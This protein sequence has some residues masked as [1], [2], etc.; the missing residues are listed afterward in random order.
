ML[1]GFT[2]AFSD[3]TVTLLHRTEEG[4]APL[5]E[6]APD[7]SDLAEQMADLREQAEA[8]APEGIATKLAIPASQILYTSIPLLTDQDATAQVHAAL[9]GLTPYEVSELRFDWTVEAGRAHLA[10]VAR[11]TLHEAEGFATDFGFNPVAF[12]A[13][14]PEGRLP[15][16]PFFGL[17][18]VAARF[19]GGQEVE[20]DDML[21]RPP[22]LAAVPDPAD[23]EALP[24]PEDPE[25]AFEAEPQP[26]PVFEA[27]PQAE[28]LAEVPVDMDIAEEEEVYAFLP[29]D[30][31]AA[32]EPE[33]EP[34]QELPAAPPEDEP[35]PL[36]LE[37]EP[38]AEAD[39]VEPEMIAP[40][41]PAA[42]DEDDTALPEDDAEFAEFPP[43]GEEELV[44]DEP[45]EDPSRLPGAESA[46]AFVVQPAATQPR[47]IPRV[48]EPP[49]FDHPSF[50]RRDTS[51]R[52]DRAPP[53]FL[54]AGPVPAGR[55]P[56]LGAPTAEAPFV[57]FAQRSGTKP[58][59]VPPPLR[60][61]QNRARS[62]AGR[63]AAMSRPRPRMLGLLLTLLLLGALALVAIASSLFTGGN[64]DSASAGRPSISIFP[65]A[66]AATR[67]EQVVIAAPAPA[68]AFDLP[69]TLIE[70]PI[71][72]QDTRPAAPQMLAQADLTSSLPPRLRPR[73]AAAVP[74]ATSASIVALTGSRP[75]TRPG[76]TIVAAAPA[77]VA[78]AEGGLRVSP[79]PQRRAESAANAAIAM[80]TG[81]GLAVD[82]SQRPEDRPSGVSQQSVNAAIVAAL[83]PPP[84]PPIAPPV[85]AVQPAPQPVPQPAPRVA[86][87]EADDEPEPIATAPRIPTSASVAQQ[88][89][90]NGKLPLGR[91]NVI[92]IS[93]SESNRSA[94]VRQKNGRVSRLKVGDRIEG[95][96]IAAITRNAIHYRKGN[97]LYAIEMPS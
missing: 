27:E 29:D 69:T 9:D 51:L 28:D 2:L 94:L 68:A 58:D 78:S 3:E 59:M 60:V 49:V 20:R 82:I 84:A 90:Q 18:M 1:P 26:E 61:T 32:H 37:D 74:E 6:V 16:E 15:E 88:A 65:M 52:A 7:A 54:R 71:I 21:L 83:E 50:T 91:T 63:G 56:P 96:V 38:L 73:S 87:P 25:P 17:T 66:Q 62:T 43:A 48:P 35:D 67:P 30:D 86:A 89:T 93:G 42:D 95:G 41:I 33:E 44:E 22:T 57:D 12:T 79:R 19:L 40:I 64:N 53:N 23:I 92:S 85:A 75:R 11:E 13:I 55:T 72:Q 5:G 36:P 70:R 76:T 14:A 46:A 97:T 81:T 47:P 77:Q 24:E 10:V 39:T 8:L 80:G 4:W 45:E 31:I 34:A